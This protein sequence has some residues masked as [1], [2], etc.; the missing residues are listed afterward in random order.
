MWKKGIE[1]VGYSGEERD[2]IISAVHVYKCQPLVV[3]YNY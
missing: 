1:I 2:E 3:V